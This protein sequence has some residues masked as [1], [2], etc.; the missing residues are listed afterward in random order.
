MSSSSASTCR[1]LSRDQLHSS[2]QNGEEEEE[3]T[4]VPLEERMKRA[5]DV[6]ASGHQRCARWAGPRAGEAIAD[7]LVAGAAV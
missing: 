2:F 7:W 4:D 6:T 3:S 5:A 1:T